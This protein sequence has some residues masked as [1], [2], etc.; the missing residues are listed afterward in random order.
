MGQE[1]VTVLWLLPIHQEE[2]R[3]AHERGVEALEQLFDA[4]GIDFLDPSRSSVS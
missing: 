2:A 4:E 1:V 3:F